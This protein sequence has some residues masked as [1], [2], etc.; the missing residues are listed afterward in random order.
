MMILPVAPKKGEKAI[1][2][3]KKFEDEFDN[4]IQTANENDIL[5]TELSNGDMV[6]D[7]VMKMKFIEKQEAVDQILQ[8]T[9]RIQAGDKRIEIITEEPR[10]INP[11]VTRAM[12]SGEVV[13][14]ETPSNTKKKILMM[15]L[16][17]AGQV[18]EVA[19]LTKWN[20]PPRNYAVNKQCGEIHLRDMSQWTSISRLCHASRAANEKDQRLRDEIFEALGKLADSGGTTK[21]YHLLHTRD[22]EELVRGT[23]LAPQDRQEAEDRFQL[24]DKMCARAARNLLQLG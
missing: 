14:G 19:P 23:L 4:W 2:L 18:T 21:I 17:T 15:A 20:L 24:I 5:Q 10:W 8:D 12:C 16:L 6:V 1:T 22:G 7:Q 11:T 3:S 13:R 9:D